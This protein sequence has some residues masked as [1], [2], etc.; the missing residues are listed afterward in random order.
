AM[1]RRHGLPSRQ[2]SPDT[3]FL[4]PSTRIRRQ[5]LSRVCATLVW[6]PIFLSAPYAALFPSVCYD[7][8]AITVNRK[9]FSPPRHFSLI[10]AIRPSGFP[11]ARKCLMRLVAA[12]VTARDIEVESLFSRF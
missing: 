6:I 9:A 7:G 12:V 2:H 11:R 3:F 8:F 5:R 1:A 4:P 10:P